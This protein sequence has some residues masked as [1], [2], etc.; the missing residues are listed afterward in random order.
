MPNRKEILQQREYLP[1]LGNAEVILVIPFYNEEQILPGFIQSL[2]TNPTPADKIYIIGVNHRSKDNSEQA[3]VRASSGYGTIAIVREEQEIA[4]VGIPRQRGLETA[5][6]LTETTTR[7]IVIGSIDADSKVS[8]H[9]LEEAEYF[10]KTDF[11]FLL[12][13]TRNDQQQFLYCVAV[14]ENDESAN[15]ALLTLVGID[16]LKHQ[17]R[18]L[19]LE[20]G[21]IETRGSGGYFFTREGYDKA[22][23]HKPVY[24]ADGTIVTGESNAVG[25]RAKRSGATALVSPYLNTASPRRIFKSLRVNKGGYELTS[26]GKT[27]ETV[28]NNQTL[29]VLET[30]QWRQ[31]FNSMLYGAIRTFVIKATAY[32][33]IPKLQNNILVPDLKELLFS[34]QKMYTLIAF[35]DDEQDAIGS[36]A[37]ISLFERAYGGL[38]EEKQKA[39]LQKIEAFIPNL[40]VLQ[41]WADNTS[42]VI[43]PLHKLG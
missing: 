4:S 19:L 26:S 39:L 14:Q 7:K 41:E 30:H 5:L 37:Y 16:W 18:A 38:G 35:K 2:R 43:E 1:P 22:H 25:I 10:L 32:E 27:F 29:P 21:A 28:S 12:F 42:L 15:L 34:V 13:P 31:Q 3:L 11:D 24:S 20:S 17:L 36:R 8:S 40:A 9:F 6:E 33:V 23:G